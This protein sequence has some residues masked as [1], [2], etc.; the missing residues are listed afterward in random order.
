MTGEQ[1][2]RDEIAALEAAVGGGTCGGGQLARAQ[3][4]QLRGVATD[5]EA[6][7]VLIRGD[8]PDFEYKVTWTMDRARKAQLLS[9][10]SWTKYPAAMLRSRAITEV[11]RQGA[12][13]ALLGFTMTPEELGV[14]VDAS[15]APVAGV[16]VDK[17]RK[18][19]AAEILEPVD[20]EIVDPDA[21]AEADFMQAT[22]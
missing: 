2:Q 19:T 15:G 22:Q 13:D 6:T 9:N 5:T 20:A 16:V 10:A 4:V 1:R 21:Q 3:P 12:S 11:C 14:E 8:D 17:P 18:V 7:A